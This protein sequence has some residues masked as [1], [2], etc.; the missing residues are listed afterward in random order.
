MITLARSL[1]CSLA[2]RQSSLRK[3]RGIGF[4]RRWSDFLQCGEQPLPWP[5]YRIC[6]VQALQCGESGVKR[7]LVEHYRYHLN[8]GTPSKSPI[9]RDIFRVACFHRHNRYDRSRSLNGFIDLLPPIDTWPEPVGVDP[10]NYPFR[11]NLSFNN[12]AK[13]PS[14]R[15]GEIKKSPSL[16]ASGGTVKCLFSCF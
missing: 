7:C 15:Q 5:S 1:N 2:R 9:V 3:A 13:S 16:L 12:S 11:S 10:R 8:I 6:K 4:S 14:D